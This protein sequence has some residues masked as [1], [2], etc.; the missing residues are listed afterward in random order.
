MLVR[1]WLAREQFTLSMSTTFF[2]Y[3]AHSGALLA[4]TEAGLRPN[5]VTGSS[6]GAVV[7]GLYGAGYDPGDEMA[8]LFEEL[9]FKDLLEFR[10]SLYWGFPVVGFY[11]QRLDALEEKCLGPESPAEGRKAIEDCR[12]PVAVSVYDAGLRKN[13]VVRSGRLAAAIAASAAVPVMMRG[14]PDGGSLLLD[15][16]VGGPRF[17]APGTIPRPSAE[18]G[19]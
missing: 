16:G 13:R 14:V 15:G 11:R 1:E 6:A 8:K 18:N 9:K 4:L 7:A 19:D 5:K 12:V 10:P 3:W 17:S 2:G